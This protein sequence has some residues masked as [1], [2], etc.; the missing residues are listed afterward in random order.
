MGTE[1]KMGTSHGNNHYF[2]VQIPSRFCSRKRNQTRGIGKQ[3]NTME[4]GPEPNPNQ[5]VF[6]VSGSDSIPNP[7][8]TTPKKDKEKKERGEQNPMIRQK[9]E[10]ENEGTK[11]AELG[12]ERNPNQKIFQDSGFGSHSGSESV[13]TK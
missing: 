9:E 6:Q 2:L 11:H 8:P 1:V 5:K 4:P 12:S 13:G 10:K 3:K 7:P